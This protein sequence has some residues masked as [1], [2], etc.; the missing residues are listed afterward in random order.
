MGLHQSIAGLFVAIDRRP[1]PA[2]LTHN[3]LGHYGEQVAVAHLRRRGYQLLAQ[4]YRAAGAEIDLVARHKKM[5]VFVEVKTRRGTHYGRPGEAVG[6]TKQRRIARAAEQYLQ[7]AGNP[8]VYS[9]F[10]VVEIEI[11]PECIPKC[12]IIENAYSAC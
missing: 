8:A 7:A 6:A 4:N 2:S 5:L 10:D 3:E 11:A 1:V 12:Q 9:R